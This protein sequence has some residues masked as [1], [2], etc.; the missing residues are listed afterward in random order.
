MTSLYAIASLLAGPGIGNT[1]H[2]AAL[3]LW[4]AG[5]LDR[6]VALGHETTPIDEA[7]IVDVRFLPRRALWFFDDKR[8]YRLKNRR[9]DRICRRY[10]DG[11]HRVVHLW[12][13][14]ATGAARLARRLGK[15]LVIDRASTHIRTQTRLLVE[16]YERAGLRYEPTYAE[17]IERCV[18]EYELADIVLTPS[19]RSYDS[20]AA[21]G[22]DLDRVVRCPFGIDLEDRAPRERPPERFRALF[23]GQLGVRKGILTLLEA[24]DRAGLDGELLLVGGEEEAIA[25][26]LRPW[27]N[28]RDVRFL[29]FR[30]DV[31][32]LMRAA[33]VFVFPT[34]EEG[35][36]LVT[37]EAMAAGLPMITTD[38][39][40]SVARRDRE[41]L[42]VAPHDADGL[43]AALTH[44][45]ENGEAMRRL[46]LA[47][48]RRVEKFPWSDYGGR[49]ALVHHM[50]AAGATGPEIKVALAA[51]WP[52]R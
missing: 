8:Y 28:R 52:E 23:V 26:R 49:V 36:A 45:A 11:P 29:G 39:A 22:C 40:G 5:L 32:E 50:A 17:T 20:F 15:K 4:R 46:G 47:A 1:A 3:G 42:F 25:A 31:P 14:Q 38:E 13:S 10:I 16:A 27:R 30:R 24:W 19:P 51:R 43:A 41:A 37:Y 12:N 2:R 35:S 33:S 44:A 6:L 48:R 7:R 18:E 34:I 21:E 9:F